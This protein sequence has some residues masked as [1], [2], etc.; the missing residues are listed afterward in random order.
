MDEDQLS[1]SSLVLAATSIEKV[2]DT[3]IGTGQ[4]VIGRSSSPQSVRIFPSRREDGH[5]YPAL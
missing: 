3:S 2:A 1:N 5:L 4:F